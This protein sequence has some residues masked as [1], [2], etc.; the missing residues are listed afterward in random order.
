MTPPPRRVPLNYSA[1][2]LHRDKAST[3]MRRHKI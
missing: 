2:L 1:K 3:G